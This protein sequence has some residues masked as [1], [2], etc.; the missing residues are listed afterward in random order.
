[1]G[2]GEEKVSSEQRI[3]QSADSAQTMLR[4]MYEDLRA[5]L[6]NEVSFRTKNEE[7]LRSWFDAKVEVLSSAQR[8]EE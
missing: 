2:L 1:M 7:D 6:D 5:S 4:Q 3:K 8:R